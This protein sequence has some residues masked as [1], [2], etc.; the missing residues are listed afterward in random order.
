MAKVTGKKTLHFTRKAWEKMWGLT[1]RAKGEISGF[2]LVDEH[3]PCKVIDFF[4]VTQECS[5][6]NSTMDPDPLHELFLSKRDE[7][8][9]MER[10]RVWWHSHASL[11]TFFSGTDEATAE[12]YASEK[13]LWSVVTNHADAVRVAKGKSPTEMYVRV[14]CFDPDFPKNRNS[15]QRY[16]IEGCEWTVG[17]VQVIPNSWFDEQIAKTRPYAIPIVKPKKNGYYP[18]GSGSL[19]GW[20]GGPNSG[21]KG[22]DKR[23]PH[24]N[25]GRQI[26]DHL[27]PALT[28]EEMIHDWEQEMEDYQYGG[29]SPAVQDWGRKWTAPDLDRNDGDDDTTFAE[30]L[31]RDRIEDNT[32]DPGEEPYFSHPFVEG[33]Y[34][35]GLIDEETA[36]SI[37]DEFEDGHVTEAELVSFMEGLWDK[38]CEKYD[39][40][41]DTYS[42]I[43][44]GLG[45]KETEE[46]PEA[47]QE[48]ACST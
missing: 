19:A 18:K 31:D 26:T 2:G 43:L 8:I 46:E 37:S 28:N 11:D 14:D 41:H 38:A 36:T 44:N 20:P 42:Q 33:M 17:N 13:A 48:A 32:G 16:T 6:S 15:P 10:W 9:P 24:G 30:L 25:P 34:L 5:G 40:D 1:L 21:W 7:G 3:D 47:P 23:Y 4:V 27:R 12:L 22:L 39:V 35:H 29:P 45:P